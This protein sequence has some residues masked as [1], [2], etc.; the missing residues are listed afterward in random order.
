M[1][2]INVTQWGKVAWKLEF[3][4]QKPLCREKRTNS[5]KLFSDLHMHTY[6]IKKLKRNSEKNLKEAWLWPGAISHLVESQ[7]CLVPKFHA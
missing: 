1:G 5:R 2:L 7:A 3:D 6:K 4:P